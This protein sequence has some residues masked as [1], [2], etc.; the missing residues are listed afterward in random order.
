MV[1]VSRSRNR[2]VNLIGSGKWN[3]VK[4]D[5]IATVQETTTQVSINSEYSGPSILRGSTFADSFF[6]SFQRKIVDD[7][8]LAD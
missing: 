6:T 5:V 4:E 1:S 8:R 7:T 3:R 2:K